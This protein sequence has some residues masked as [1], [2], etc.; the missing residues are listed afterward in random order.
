[1]LQTNDYVHY[2][3][4]SF[5]FIRASVPRRKDGSLA[6]E[7]YLPQLILTF[8]CKGM[9]A[10]ERRYKSHCDVSAAALNINEVQP[11][12]YKKMYF[13]GGRGR[14]NNREVI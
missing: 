4:Y 5:T 13:Q 10:K 1:M 8:V 7:M 14:Q 9:C 3:S 6:L 11:K 2:L 12:N